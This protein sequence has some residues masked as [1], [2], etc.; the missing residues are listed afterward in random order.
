MK[1]IMLLFVILLAISCKESP[2]VETTE[3][4]STINAKPISEDF[5][6]Q[7]LYNP[8]T[9]DFSLFDA[10]QEVEGNYYT[11]LRKVSAKNSLGVEREYIYK[12]KLEYLG[13]NE[14]DISSWKLINM[15]SEEYR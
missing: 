10:S 12:V 8:S 5:I 7:D 9:A 2:N 1:K 15:Q 3:S 6:K 14:Y 13:G 11:I 4:S